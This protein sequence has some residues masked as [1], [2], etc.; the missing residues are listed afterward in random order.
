M[1]TSF[2]RLNYLQEQETNRR[3]NYNFTHKYD[4]DKLAPHWAIE[5]NR[6]YEWNIS[7]KRIYTE[8]RYWCNAHEN[9][10]KPVQKRRKLTLSEVMCILGGQNTEMIEAATILSTL[11]RKR[12]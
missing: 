7:F 6:R 9:I 11:K 4:R 3:D 5:Y 12:D 8:W 2:D 10:W 1:P